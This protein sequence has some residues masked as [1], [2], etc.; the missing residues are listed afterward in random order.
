[1][2]WWQGRSAMQT[3]TLTATTVAMAMYVFIAS[4]VRN[5]QY[6]TSSIVLLNR[7]VNLW[8]HIT[9]KNH[10]F[11]PFP[12][13]W[14][15]KEGIKKYPFFKALEVRG[16][17]GGGLLPPSELGNGISYGHQIFRR[18]CTSKNKSIQQFWCRYDVVWRHYDV[19]HI[20]LMA[21]TVINRLFS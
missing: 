6:A 7:C 3:I 8:V 9:Y 14:W 10:T 21:K 5:Y 20:I 17:G 15:R 4:L 11:L 2:K 16:T 19:I 18:W 1:M 13:F 12:I